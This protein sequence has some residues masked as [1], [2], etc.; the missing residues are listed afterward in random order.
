[1]AAQ[2][3]LRGALERLEMVLEESVAGEVIWRADAEVVALHREKAA[4]AHP[5]IEHQRRKLAGGAFDEARP[6]ASQHR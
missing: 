2:A 3:L 6:E 4:R 1:M 5:G